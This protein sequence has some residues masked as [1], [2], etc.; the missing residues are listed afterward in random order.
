MTQCPGRAQSAPAIHPWHHTV[1]CGSSFAHLPAA[2]PA[3]AAQPPL[4]RSGLG[5]KQSLVS[6]LALLLPGHLAGRT[7]WATSAGCAAALHSRRLLL[8]RV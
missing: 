7:S 5:P 1:F 4:W 2:H 3:A 8:V 6:S